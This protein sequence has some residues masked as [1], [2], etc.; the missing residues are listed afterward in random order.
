MSW[1]HAFQPVG[2]VRVATPC[3]SVGQLAIVSTSARFPRVATEA[4]QANDP[5]VAAAKKEIDDAC[6]LIWVV[7]EQQFS[8]R[9][10]AFYR[11]AD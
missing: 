3:F 7:V 1:R 8:Y 9:L 4:F 11:I 6:A 5:E 10:Q 2:R